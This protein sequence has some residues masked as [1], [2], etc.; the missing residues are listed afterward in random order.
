MRCRHC[1]AAI[2]QIN[3]PTV[4]YSVYLGTTLLL[5]GCFPGDGKNHQPDPEEIMNDLLE[6]VSD[7]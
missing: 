6:V 1:G 3:H 5:Y 4:W 2:F 7:L